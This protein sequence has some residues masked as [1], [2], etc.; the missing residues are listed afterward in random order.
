[1]TARDPRFAQA[2]E[3]T[4]A[5]YDVSARNYAERNEKMSPYWT[6]RMEQFLAL[7]ADAEERRP[8][9]EL[10]RPGDDIELDDYLNF[11]PLLDAGSGTGRDARAFAAAGQIVLGVDLS[12]GMLD[13]AG[14]RTARRL[15][16]GAIRYALMDL[17]RLELPDAS[18]RGVW[19]SASMLHLPLHVAPRAMAELARVARPGAPLALFL[20]ERQPDGEAERFEPYPTDAAPDGRRF[21][22]YYTADEAQALVTGAGLEI[23]SADV[24]TELDH[25]RQHHW[26]SVLARKP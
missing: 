22:A 3:L 16:T 14:E 8:I 18:C 26:V 2:V 24:S 5:T 12:Q 6:E 21:Y 4:T 9:P 1:M 19:C 13:E 15:P 20:K 23:V 10:G 7:M 17:R 11:I 25:T